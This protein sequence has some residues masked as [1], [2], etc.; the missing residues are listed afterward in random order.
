MELRSLPSI[1]C[2]QCNKSGGK[3][4]FTESSSPSLLCFAPLSLWPDSMPDAPPPPPPPPPRCCRV[5]RAC[6]RVCPDCKA[7]LSTLALHGVCSEQQL[8]SRS[9]SLHLNQ[10]LMCSACCKFKIPRLFYCSSTCLSHAATISSSTWHMR[11]SDLPDP[12]LSSLLKPLGAPAQISAAEYALSGEQVLQYRAKGHTLLPGL[13][14]R[15][16]VEALREWVKFTALRIL[17]ATAAQSGPKGSK[18]FFRAHNLWQENDVMR[19]FV[20]SP[21][22]GG[23]ARRL[24]GCERVRLYQDSAFFKE[25]GDRPSPWHQDLAAAPFETDSF[26]TIWITLTDIKPEQGALVFAEGSHLTDYRTAGHRPSPLDQTA[27]PYSRDGSYQHATAE[28]LEGLGFPISQPPPLMHAGDATFHSG[29]TFH[30]AAANTSKE[31]ATRYAVA[32]S[33]FADG[34]KAKKG[35]MRIL[36]D[37]PT[38]ALLS[39]DGNLEGAKEIRSPFTPLIP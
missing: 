39:R 24:L 31:A 34:T 13:V 25:A 37:Y 26:G 32:I 10:N 28:T 19:A 4:G 5:A 2:M 14:A 30:G 15:E 17:S 11:F 29:W 18:P 33:F 22:I 6:W 27:A 8:L 38:I 35:R 7:P 9:R 16:E 20:M 1:K 12:A 23:V 36:D 21:R 3:R